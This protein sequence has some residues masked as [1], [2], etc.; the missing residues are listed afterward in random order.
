[1]KSNQALHS[2]KLLAGR[3][4][5]LTTSAAALG[6]LSLGAYVSE[7]PA[8]ASRLA[9]EKLRIAAIGVTGRAGANLGEVARLGEEIVAL[10][11]VD[12]NLM[13]KVKD[14][15]SGATCYRDFRDMLDK[16]AAKIDAVLVGTPDHTHAPAAA[17]ALR[18]GKHVYCEKPLTHTVLEAR[19]LNN[20]AKEKK[21]VTQM[22]NQ[23]HAGDNYRR[24][25]EI[26]QSGAIGKVSDVHVWAGAQY[27]GAKFTAAEAP[28]GL[29]WN[30]WLG[31]AA[32][33]PYSSDVHPFQWRRFWEYGNGAL[34][35]FGCH[36]MD[37][38]HWALDLKA[39]TSVEA[40]G[41]PVDSV[42]CPDW[43]E[44]TYEY[45]ARG[46]SPAV[47]LFW[48]DSG[49]RPELLKK[50][51]HSKTKP[52]DWS[53]GLL[54]IGSDGMLL[55]NYG[56]YV[57][58]PE[59]KFEG[60]KLPA[61]TI[62][63]SIGHH[64]EWTTAIR[65]GGTTTCNFEYAGALTEAVLLGTVAYR[66]GKKLDWNAADMKFTNYAEAEPLLHKEYRKGWTL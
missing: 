53:G 28:A 41:P 50:L 46:E 23:I 54:F 18:L 1:M 24:V 49:R 51:S 29:D 56:D 21:L 42:S 62:P 26:I 45:P 31:P 27:S 66:A 30:L 3:R 22:G 25:V 33:R 43:C 64:R 40:K 35:D 59:E 63:R 55:A 19:T 11:D 52:A 37:L 36:F 14:Q 15:H 2:S 6:A 8:R 5:F 57:L 13:A 32:D 10:A 17:M 60:Y 61:E 47:K 44:A 39:P 38:A 9:S 7:S 4:K 16:Q 48:Y 12:D 20:L 34:G 65:D 58:F